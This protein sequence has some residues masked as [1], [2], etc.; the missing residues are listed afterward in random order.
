[1][2]R[3][4]RLVV[5][6][7]PHHVTQRGNRRQQ[8]FFGAAD[9]HLYRELLAEACSDAAVS[10]WAYCLM[11]NHVH[12]VLVPEAASGL[13][14][15]IKPA[16][17][18]Y[19]WAINR[20]ER[21]TGYLWQGRFTSYPMD[22]QHLLAATQYIELNPVRARL[23]PTPEAWPW[24]SARAHLTGRP[25]GLADPGPLLELVPD[26][27]AFLAAGMEADAFRKRAAEMERACHAGLPQGSAGF[28]SALEARTGRTLTPRRRGRKPRAQGHEV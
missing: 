10:V 17:Q 6:G 11:P 2:P 21:W 5:P 14:A 9:Y 19:T 1:M 20:R 4:A 18:K 27:R 25:D 7:S 23:T 8:V 13:A 24:S 28:I 16:H 3:V 12:L 15:A 26:W 22:G